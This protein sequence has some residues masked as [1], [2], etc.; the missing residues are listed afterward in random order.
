MVI[1]LTM[2]NKWCKMF[3][4]LFEK[5][6]LEDILL[7]GEKIDGLKLAHYINLSTLNNTDKILVFQVDTLLL[8]NKI[9][10]NQILGLSFKNFNQTFGTDIILHNNFAM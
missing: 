1:M 6:G 9:Y 2:L 3:S 10:K 4:K 5:V 7:K 8:N